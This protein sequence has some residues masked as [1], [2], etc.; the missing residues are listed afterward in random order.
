MEN[1]KVTRSWGVAAAI[2]AAVVCIAAAALTL[3][4]MAKAQ[5]P[6][7]CCPSVVIQW[8]P[9]S[10]LEA[11]FRE[12]I[13][14]DNEAII[15]GLQAF[16][17]NPDMTPA[18]ILKYVGNTYLKNPRLWSIRLGWLEGWD[19]I[20]PEL[21][22]IIHIDSHPSITSVAV[23]I[24]YQPYIGAKTP[25]EDIDAVA[26]IRM[27]FSASPDGTRMDGTLKHSRVCEIS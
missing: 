13:L 3:T 9:Q 15:N 4:T 26:E 20:L 10:I 19:Q 22:G 18:D 25:A 21:K 1:S 12:R 16:A 7:A 27:T 5:Q 24:E 14:K 23:L 17:K 8:Q 2:V 6:A 11:K